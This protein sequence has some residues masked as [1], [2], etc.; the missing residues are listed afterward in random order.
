MLLIDCVDCSCVNSSSSA[1]FVGRNEDPVGRW[2]A[3]AAGESD[4]HAGDQ[5]T[6]EA[7]DLEGRQQRRCEGLVSTAGNRIKP[8]R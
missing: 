8:G 7:D 5:V 2:P 1:T 3:P 4:L 6:A